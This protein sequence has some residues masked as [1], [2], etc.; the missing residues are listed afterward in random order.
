V[1]R[2]LRLEPPRLLRLSK[3]ADMYHGGPV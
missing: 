2:W 3:Q 1:R